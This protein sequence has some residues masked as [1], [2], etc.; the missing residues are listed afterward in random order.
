MIPT[1]ESVPAGYAI[2]P[3]VALR[4]QANAFNDGQVLVFARVASGRGSERSRSGPPSHR[5]LGLMQI[6]RETIL[7]PA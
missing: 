7:P 1:R 5:R 3:Y 6:G 4:S 2:A